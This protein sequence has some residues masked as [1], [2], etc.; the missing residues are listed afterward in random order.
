M[1]LNTEFLQFASLGTSIYRLQVQMSVWPEKP[2]RRP[3]HRH[4]AS[5]RT[6]VRSAFQNFAEILS[7][8]E[9]RPDAVAL[10]SDGRTFTASNFHIKALRIS[11]YVALALGPR[12]LASRHLNFECATCLMDEYVRTGIHI[13]RTV[14]TIFPYLYFGK[15][16]HS[17]S[18]TKWRPDVLLKHLDG[19]KLEQFEAS[20]HRGRSRRKVLVI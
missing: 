7:W 12:R 2:G 13:P 11:I 17:W 8:F 16:S 3:D 9:P 19:C 6:I 15:K 1:E 4:K 14:A 18:N 20:R 5:R 10:L